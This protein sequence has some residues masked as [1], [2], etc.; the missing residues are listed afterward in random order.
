MN[1]NLH[2]KKRCRAMLGNLVENG[3]DV[4]V[5]KVLLEQLGGNISPEERR[6]YEGE[7][8]EMLSVDV[9]TYIEKT[10]S[11]ANAATICGHMGTNHEEKLL[12]R[13]VLVNTDVN[14]VIGPG[15]KQIGNNFVVIP[16]VIH[17]DKIND[18]EYAFGELDMYGIPEWIEYTAELDGNL[19]HQVYAKGDK[20]FKTCRPQNYIDM[21]YMIPEGILKKYNY[22]VQDS[23][24]GSL[25]L[26][27]VDVGWNVYPYDDETNV[28]K[29]VTKQHPDEKCEI[30]QRTEKITR[31]E[32]CDTHGNI[33]GTIFPE[34]RADF[35]KKDN[36]AYLSLDP[37]GAVSVRLMTL[38]G[39]GRSGDICYM[40]LIHPVT[41]MAKGELHRAVERC[42]FPLEGKGT[43]FDSLLQKFFPK[44]F[45]G[46]AGLMV[47]GRVWLPDQNALFDALKACPGTMSA[48]MTDLGVVSNMKEM[49]TRSNLSPKDKESCMSALKLYIGTMILEGVFALAKEGYAVR[50]ENL[51]VLISYP[52]NGSGEGVTRLIIRAIRG[53][54]SLVNEY[55]VPDNQLVVDENVFFYSESEAT[56]EWH[57]N[58]PPGK[59]FMGRNVAAGTPDYGHSTHDYSLRVNDHLYMF[60]IPYAAQYITN[61]TLAKVYDGNACALMRCFLGGSQE[62]KI[63]ALES[64]EQSMESSQG[65]LYERL[66]FVLSLNRLFSSCVFKVTGSNAD[67]FQMKVQQITEAKLNIAIP[68]Y[69]YTV[70]RALKDG[71]LKLDSSIILAPVGKGSLAIDNTVDDFE[72]RFIQ[73][74]NNQIQYMINNDEKFPKN[75]VF[76]GVIQLLPNNDREKISVAQGMIDIE[77]NSGADRSGYISVIPD[78]IEYYLDLAYSVD[79]SGIAA[80]EEVSIELEKFNTPAMRA[81]YNAMREEIYDQAFDALVN[82]YRYEQFEESFNRWGYTG[83][84]EGVAYDEA[85]ILDDTIRTIVKQQFQNLVAELKQCRKELVMSCP[86]IEKEMMCSAMIDL[87]IERL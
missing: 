34:V 16:P 78:P 68:A 29:L 39:S 7:V 48:A 81:R 44:G 84:E 83:I 41:P 12:S 13:P 28:A 32:L 30:H 6:I 55:M 35:E 3:T 58:N 43:H 51:K 22:L 75:T 80:R 14:P 79:Q 25:G 70:I 57:K 66:G 5:I 76:T 24:A 60:S 77:E 74:L 61:A 85:G 56:A 53:A 63:R 33:L 4:K 86:Y 8:A 23:A 10:A 2:I 65:K 69:A 47:E 59:S 19:Y 11:G 52:E 50:A 37:A 62:L 9:T 49:L 87:A 82:S 38:S 46:W 26:D 42:L 54:L 18:S 15:M 20:G 45:G 72:R 73:R 27:E 1:A 40:N 17:V 31:M 71:E 21:S 64:I 67:I 36:I